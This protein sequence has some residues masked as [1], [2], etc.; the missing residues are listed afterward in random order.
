MKAFVLFFVFRY[1]Y[2]LFYIWTLYLEPAGYCSLEPD[3]GPCTGRKI[4]W[5]YDK[6][7]VCKQFYYGGCRGNGNRFN[8]KKDCEIKCSVSQGN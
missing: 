1:F 7:G 8:T 5:F 6:D 4:Q 3:A 2:A